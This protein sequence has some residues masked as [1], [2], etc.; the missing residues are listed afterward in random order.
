M[1]FKGQRIGRYEIVESLGSGGFGT[2]YLAIDTWL[3]KEVA[4]KVPHKQ[5]E[6]FYKLLKE[7][8]VQAGLKHRNIVELY[9][10]E[11]IDSLFFMVME[12]VRGEGLDSIIRSKGRL[13]LYLAISYLEQILEAVRYA[14]KK[15]VIHRDLRPTNILID[16]EGTVK[17]TDFG[18]STWLEKN[19]FAS[20]KIGSPPYMAPEQF[21]GKTTFSSDIYSVGC[22]AYEMLTGKP[23]VVDPNPFKIREYVLKRKVK[24]LNKINHEVPE[25]FSKIVMRAIE[26]DISKRF[27][28]AE[29]FLRAIELFRNGR[30]KKE[31]NIGR[32]PKI[33]IPKERVSFG[34]KKVRKCWN[35][36]RELPPFVDKCPFCGADV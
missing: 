9:T 35:C 23:P 7:P 4:I 12:Y 31:T 11:K 19:S 13:S 18:I 14:H 16:E 29:E 25:S 6:E 21:D 5:T 15:N 17:I 10:V 24:P 8:R 32:E 27:A 26:P 1:L 2:V 36:K 30:A 22:I 28:T 3:T 34:E 20:T 33:Y